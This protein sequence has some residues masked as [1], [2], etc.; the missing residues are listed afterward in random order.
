MRSCAHSPMG[1]Q[2]SMEEAARR[3]VAMTDEDS[4]DDQSH[5]A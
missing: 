4:G 2:V 5:R 1:W 3:I